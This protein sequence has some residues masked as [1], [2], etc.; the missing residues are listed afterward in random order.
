MTIEK[1]VKV[2]YA[3]LKK[4]LYGC[5]QSALHWYNLFHD[6]LKQMGFTVYPYDPC[7]ANCIIDGSQCTIA[8]Y[9]DDTKISHVNSDVVTRIIDILEG[10]F[11]KMTVTRGKENVFLGMNIVYTQERTAKITMKQY[12]QEALDKSKMDMKRRPRLGRT[13]SMSTKRPSPNPRLRVSTA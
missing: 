11:G 5:V 9:V 6:T 8:W 3:R 10:H 4:A 1:G 2:L 13:Y 12:L 7:V